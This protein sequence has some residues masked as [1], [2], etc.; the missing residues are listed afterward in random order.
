MALVVV[1]LVGQ[2]QVLLVQV[3]V[4]LVL[5]VQV[6]VSRRQRKI[7]VHMSQLLLR[8]KHWRMRPMLLLC[9]L[10]PRKLR[11]TMLLLRPLRL[12]LRRRRRPMLV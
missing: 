12:P 10:R 5:Q 4:S 7:V 2:L 6:V 11:R 1:R 9:K 3:L 8:L